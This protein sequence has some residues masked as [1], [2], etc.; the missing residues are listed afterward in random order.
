VQQPRATTTPRSGQEFKGAAKS[1][2]ERLRVQE[3]DHKSSQE[4]REAAKT[5]REL[6]GIHESGQEFMR[7]DK[8]S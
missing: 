3:R 2:K 4:F 5:S 6:P 8:S 7:A 1:S